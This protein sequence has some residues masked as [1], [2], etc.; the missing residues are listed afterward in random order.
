MWVLPGASSCL[1]AWVFLNMCFISFYKTRSQHFN[2]ELMGAA[3]GWYLLPSDGLASG[4]GLVSH[5][6]WCSAVLCVLAA[7]GLTG[8]FG[9]FLLECGLT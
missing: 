1:S 6:R 3:K 4:R 7:G 9:A 8:G 2:Y 5:G